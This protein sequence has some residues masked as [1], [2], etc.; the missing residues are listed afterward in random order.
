MSLFKHVTTR[1]TRVKTM[2]L[3]DSFKKNLTTR[4]L[5]SLFK[6]R[7]VALGRTDKVFASQWLDERKVVCG[8]KSNQVRK[9]MV[10]YYI[11]IYNLF[12]CLHKHPGAWGGG[13][14]EFYLERLCLEVPP[15]IILCTIF[16]RKGMPFIT[17]WVVVS[18]GQKLHYNGRETIVSDCLLLLFHQAWMSHDSAVETSND[19]TSCCFVWNMH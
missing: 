19:I 18:S 14:V 1:Q 7:E 11:I 9:T 17:L 4:Q 10:G 2:K 12:F 3:G 16:D 6:E 8:T 5:P 15:M 13:R